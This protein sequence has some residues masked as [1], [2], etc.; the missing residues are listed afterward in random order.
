MG[1]APVLRYQAYVRFTLSVL[2]ELK[3]IFAAGQR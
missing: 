1:S 2:F 3:F